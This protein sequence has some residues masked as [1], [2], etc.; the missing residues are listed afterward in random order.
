M[1]SPRDDESSFGGSTPEDPAH[2]VGSSSDEDC[3][4]PA[5]CVPVMTEREV[6]ALVQQVWVCDEWQTL[7]LDCDLWAGIIPTRLLPVLFP[8]DCTMANVSIGHSNMPWGGNGVQVLISPIK[9]FV[10][11]DQVQK[12]C[13]SIEAYSVESVFFKK[14]VLEDLPLLQNVRVK[15]RHII[16][17]TSRHQISM[18]TLAQ[19]M[20]D[21][22]ISTVFCSNF[23]VKTRLMDKE[24]SEHE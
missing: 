8:V 4:L 18:A 5:P 23:G 7:P 16:S 15:Q 11:G 13:D 9:L 10:R 17:F 2:S 20:L 14:D 22:G 3:P 1:Y 6:A 19:C 24:W 12:L 21:V